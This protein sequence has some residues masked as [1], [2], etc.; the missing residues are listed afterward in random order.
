MLFRKIFYLLET[1]SFIY[2]IFISIRGKF[3]LTSIRVVRLILP[4]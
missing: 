3:Y 4:T 1:N 2:S